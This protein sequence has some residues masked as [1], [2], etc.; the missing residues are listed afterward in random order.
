[1]KTLGII[2]LTVILSI[3]GC[4]LFDS[5]DSE[6]IEGRLSFGFEVSAFKPC[7]VEEI[8]W[9]SGPESLFRQYNETADTEYE[10]VYARLKGVKSKKGAYGHMGAYQREFAVSEALVVRKLISGDCR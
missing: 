6:E 1:M 10:K 9:V 3:P 4:G 2:V 7:G 8:W 5:D